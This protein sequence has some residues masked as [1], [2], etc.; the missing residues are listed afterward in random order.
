MAILMEVSLALGMRAKAR[1]CREESRIAMFMGVLLARAVD[2]QARRAAWAAW[3]V[4]LGV[5][6]RAWEE[7]VE[8]EVEEGIMGGGGGGG[9][10]AGWVGSLF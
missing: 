2:W 1:R 10:V 9:E 4:R 6:V 7:E 8:G 5:C 3:R